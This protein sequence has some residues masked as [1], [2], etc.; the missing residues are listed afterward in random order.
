MGIVYMVVSSIPSTHTNW[1]SS[2]KTWLQPLPPHSSDLIIN[3]SWQFQESRICRLQ[4]TTHAISPTHGC[5][6]HSS[7]CSKSIGVP[8]FH[9][10]LVQTPLLCFPES[11]QLDCTLLV[12][13]VSIVTRWSC[14]VPHSNG[15]SIYK[16]S[17]CT[18]TFM[19]GIPF[20]LA[21]I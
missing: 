8:Y 12:T 19:P 5:P 18:P 20:I 6:Y 16:H 11:P 1:D 15:L 17:M 4:S 21:S 7:F 2:L 14:L 10:H 3:V 9:L 13:V